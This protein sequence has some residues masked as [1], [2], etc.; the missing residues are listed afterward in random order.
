MSELL[1]IFDEYDEIPR[2][3]LQAMDTNFCGA[4]HHRAWLYNGEWPNLC[5][6]EIRDNSLGCIHTTSPVLRRGIESLFSLGRI[7]QEQGKDLLLLL[8]ENAWG[9]LWRVDMLA[10]TISNELCLSE[11]KRRQNVDE[12]VR[13]YRQ[14]LIGLSAEE[15]D[16]ATLT[17]DSAIKLVKAKHEE[18]GRLR[19]ELRE[20][21]IG[22]LC[23]EAE[24]KS[25]QDK[26]TDFIIRHRGKA[27]ES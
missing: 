13:E 14:N 4:P 11:N 7:T 21:L 22:C 20:V 24:T 25:I 23:P 18:A 26:V 10:I 9:A 17:S 27:E 15:C 19:I 6:Q 5:A 8:Y 16:V 12:E 2:E 1:P 3:A